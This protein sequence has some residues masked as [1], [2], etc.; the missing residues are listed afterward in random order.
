MLSVLSLMTLLAG[1]YPRRELGAAAEA[2]RVGAA[3]ASCWKVAT[4]NKTLAK[5][6]RD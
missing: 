2:V 4:A 6:R 5:L 3:K 1:L